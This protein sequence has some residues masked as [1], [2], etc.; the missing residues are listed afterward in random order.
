MQDLKNQISALEAQLQSKDEEITTLRDSLEKQTVQR[1]KGIAEVKS[2]PN[3]RQI[4][5]ALLNAGYDPGVIDG[6]KGRKTREA[7]R[8]FQKANGLAA[9]G[10]VGKQ[11]WALLK[12]YLY[13]KVK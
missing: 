6:K 13:K 11:T 9:D 3:M 7:V 8:A 5:I 1:P 2:R 10:R 4:Q 12:K